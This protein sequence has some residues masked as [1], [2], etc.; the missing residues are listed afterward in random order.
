VNNVIELYEAIQ[1]IDTGEPFSL[2]YV[3]ADR[4][5]GT[6]GQIKKVTNWVKC[7]L[8]TVPEPI[9]RRNKMFE[10]SKNPNHQQHKTKN[11]MNPATRDI[12]KV[13]VRLITEFNGKRV[14]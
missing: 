10:A 3:T 5:K 12:R 7:D 11:I 4:N 14:V 13:H 6:G 2:T 9:L 8:A 1:L